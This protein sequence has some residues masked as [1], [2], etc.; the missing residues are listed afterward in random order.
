MD[1]GTLT[2][3]H[4]WISKHYHLVA[5]ALLL[6]LMAGLAQAQDSRNPLDGYTPTGLAP[7]AP[8]GSYALSGF[9]NV[10]P[11]SGGLNFTLP[12]LS[13]GGRGGAGYTISL[14]IEQKWTVTHSTADG[15]IPNQHYDFY[16][17]EF[18]Q[19]INGTRAG[20]GPGALYGRQIGDNY[21]LCDYLGTSFPSQTL[22]RFTFVMPDGTE[23]ELRD[24]LTDGRP[25]YVGVCPNNGTSR[26]RVFR[27]ADG[28]SA[29]FISDDAVVDTPFIYSGIIGAAG[30]LFLK[31]GTRY[32]IDGGTVTWV[33]D[34]NGNKL[35]F[36][37]N[38]VYGV[39]SIKDSLNREI[40]IDY[41][42]DDGA[43]YGLCDRIT[44]R[45]FG[46]AP[47]IIRISRDS[48]GGVLRTGSS[49]RTCHD[50]FPHINN[51]SSAGACGGG[52]LVS[53]VWLPDD[54]V[55][56]R[57]YQF[58]YN[59][60][61]ELA[62]VELP[63]GG[64]FEYDWDGGYIN[65]PS[66]GDVC[67]DC[68][69]YRRVIERRVLANGVDVDNRITFSKP[70]TLNGGLVTSAD[71][72]EVNQ[73]EGQILK[74]S[75]RHYYYGHAV[76]SVQNNEPLS[77]PSWDEGKEYRTE[78]LDTN[79]TV[80]RRTDNSW[81]FTAPIWQFGPAFNPRIIETDTTLE[82]SGPNLV[83]RQTFDYD[84]YN[85][86]TDVYQYDFGGGLLR[87][88]H[89]DYLTTND[90][91]G[92]AYDTVKPNNT[93]P[94]ASITVHLRNLPTLQTIYDGSGVP[95]AKT[96]FE[97]DNYTSDQGYLHYTM[98]PRT[99][100]TGLCDGTSQNCNG[101]P[102]FSDQNYLPRGNATMITR[103]LLNASGD[104]AGTIKG[105]SQ[106]DI[107]GNV[108]KV[109]DPRSTATNVI[110]TTFDFTDCFGSPDGNVVTNSGATELGS[111]SSYAF[112]SVITNALGQTA[113]AQFDFHTGRPVD[114]MDANG[115]ISSGYSDNDPLDRPTKIIRGVN[116]DASVKNQT[117]FSY[118][119]TN[120]IITTTKDF[121][122]FDEA[123]PLK[124]Q[125]V[126]DGLGRVTDKRQYENATDYI[127]VR[128]TYDALGRP[129]TTSNP[130]RSGEVILWTTTAYDDLSRVISVTTPDCAV[131]TTAYSGNRVFVADQNNSDQLRKKRISKTDGLGRL[132]DIWEVTGADSATESITFPGWSDVTAGYHTAYVYDALEDLTNVSQGGQTRSFEYDSLKRLSAAVN[133]ESGRI[134][135]QYD[136][137]DNLLIKKDARGVSAHYEYDALSR[138]SRRW[139]NGRD[140]L[141]DTTNNVPAL[142][143]GVGA[144]DEVRYFYDAQDLPTGAP[145]SPEFSRG[146][147]IG[148]LVAV[149]YGGGNSGDYYGY[150][151]A[152]RIKP[153]IQ[154]IGG[155]NYKVDPTYNVAGAVTTESYPSTRTVANTFDSA[156]RTTGVTGELGGNS[157][158]YASGVTYAAAG[159]MTQEQFGTGT[160]IYNKLFYNSRGQLAEIREG[161]TP[162]NTE[163]S[164]G[165]IINY[166][167]ASCDG[168][169]GGSTS[170]TSMTDNNG[171]LQK[172]QVY[173]SSS[174]SF[175]QF[176]EYDSLNRL[177]SVRENKNGGA[178]NWK[179]AYVYDR[180][181][182]RT[183]N[184]STS[185]T[186]GGVN[187]LE[188]EIE[189]G[190]NRLL[191]H[192]DLA[193]TDLTLRQ[194]QY[195]AAGNLKK[196]TYTG[197]GD[198]IYDAENRMIQAWGN[199]QWQYY[200]Y[201]GEGRRVARNVNGAVTWQ[202]YGLGG[203]LVAEY[204][205]NVAASTPQ[206]E[207]GYRNGQLLITATV[208]SGWGAA[209]TIHD[210][211]LVI[212]Q[213]TV[214]SRH[215]T[216]LRD[217]INS[218][219]T[220]KGLSNFSWQYSA[221]TNDLISASPILEMRTALD[222]A[223]GA[224][225]SGYSAGLAQGE[226][227]KA[228]HIQE[229]R[230]RVLGAWVSSS[231]TD[232]RW[233]VSDQLGTPRMIFDQSG[234]LTV[235]DPNGNY[236]SGMTRHD[237]LPFGE[238][239]FGGPP[240]QP[241]AGG[242]TITQGYSGDSTRQKFTQKERDNETG[243]DYF[244]ARYYSSIEGRFTSPDEFSGGPT[245]LFADVTSH[246]PTFYADPAEP[247]SLDKY[248]YGL[249]NPMRYLD[250]DGHQSVH[251][252]CLGGAC[253]PGPTP[254]PQLDFASQVSSDTMYGTAKGVANVAAGV[255]NA[256]ND[257]IN[258]LI[259]PFTS[260]RV[261]SV[262]T[263][264]A[265]TPG[266][267]GAM[268]AV[269]MIALFEGARSANATGGAMVESSRT[270]AMVSEMHQGTVN[271]AALA[272]AQ[273]ARGPA[274]AG[275]AARTPDG[276]LFSETSG[277][278]FTHNRRVQGALDSIPASQRSPY[279]GACVECRLMS[280]IL[281]SGRS[282]RG[283]Q[284]GVF[285]TRRLTPMTPCT[286]CR[287]VM[288]RLGVN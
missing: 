82:P 272:T 270:N 155:V 136:N 95:R 7:G 215:I 148:R 115:V 153:K 157:R 84:Q 14:P 238:E 206:K 70:D 2:S 285:S 126:F 98:V 259:S 284:M 56:H 129:S 178:D 137:S 264:Q 173:I 184:S 254:P 21:Q 12:L 142:P 67:F 102:N 25:Y 273:N 235:T 287:Q 18:N 112:P 233:L 186:Y 168:M 242:R 154:R 130:F 103:Y 146:Q 249:N 226:P 139:Y 131:V 278:G 175:T 248:Q 196:D 86:Q 54:G 258:V 189:P 172:Q 91:N 10:N 124:S 257:G 156:G 180:F 118:D 109:I 8:A 260:A 105:Y 132:T 30:Y 122:T 183:I 232:L 252:D 46:G 20:Y 193:Q 140:L 244:L 26:G 96:R 32:R 120:R 266:E 282:L 128:Q 24:V 222:E 135:Y 77:Y 246:N 280:R 68:S 214:Q 268:F 231:S 23:Y 241:G 176:Y 85:N 36:E 279:H 190:T 29:T 205:Q 80:L 245:E 61:S 144:S 239:L 27:T 230:D 152:G 228:I 73:Y 265:E 236:V 127:T 181:G 69:I 161:T 191:A 59:S 247:Q 269:G 199:G 210:N 166:Y 106:Y 171:N 281:D 271:D 283:T 223:L 97:Y 13:V 253:H 116:Q 38:S 113:H 123:S 211:P 217:A 104:D 93:S 225:A 88:T 255:P 19:F 1:Q 240:S 37:Y 182:N 3:A 51:A 263:F 71:F 286:S 15:G 101:S 213:T 6:P 187:N 47:R 160:P 50:M 42:V 147:S 43:P 151:G 58:R 185:A 31:D 107:A 177:Q 267:K 28:T 79:G 52:D 188:F 261:P 57:S 92:V 72:I 81:T 167:S 78:S 111:Q 145:T 100:I 39:T 94:D 243:L 121:N 53:A 159:Q 134:K 117:I 74:T 207:Y 11:Y 75:E 89:T 63:T 256:I 218:L 138:V 5:L 229:L 198:R 227:V 90:V 110:A 275:G 169:C 34:R 234:S 162:N 201:D 203:E 99:S 119:D 251:A 164:R 149:T 158:T 288:T 108:V 44:Y 197:T 83:S 41:L 277:Y 276:K 62:R 48:L 224:P 55:H 274:G 40:T 143:A 45:G 179:Q 16:D 262:P 65:G 212:N 208:T 125:T 60:Y 35:S 66:G 114:G 219:R 250:P 209:P 216:E 17:P 165:A 174:D 194:M 202:I 22:T 87:H 221:T 200:T 64:A 204:A 133:P 195:D 4:L 9:E 49:L 170:T 76:A 192:G 33:S 141:T 220:H 163:S 237:Y 150:D